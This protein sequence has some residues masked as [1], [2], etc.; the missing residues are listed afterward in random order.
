[1]D[2]DQEKELLKQ[3]FGIDAANMRPGTAVLVVNIDGATSIL[4][5]FFDELHMTENELAKAVVVF[6]AGIQYKLGDHAFRDEIIDFAIKNRPE[7]FTVATR[8]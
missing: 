4:G 8:Q 1:M 2:F 7:L 3:R 5:S 6:M